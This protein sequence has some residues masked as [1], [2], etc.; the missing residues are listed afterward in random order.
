MVLLQVDQ[1]AH[2]HPVSCSQAVLL[3]DDYIYS[4]PQ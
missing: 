3:F 4:T 1:S 2:F